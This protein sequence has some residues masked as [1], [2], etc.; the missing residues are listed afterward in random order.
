[1]LQP[2]VD[3]TSKGPPFG[4]T[5]MV[6]PY[7]SPREIKSSG[8]FSVPAS[9]CLPV[10]KF[11]KASGPFSA[12]HVFSP[13]GGPHSGRSLANRAQPL[14]QRNSSTY[15]VRPGTSQARDSHRSMT[16]PETALGRR[17]AI[18]IYGGGSPPSAGGPGE[19]KRSYG[20]DAS[21]RCWVGECLSPHLRAIG[22]APSQPAAPT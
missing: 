4:A 14:N 16:Y 9:G 6:P 19:F 5:R 21:D 1:M 3:N 22:A 13:H 15:L 8:I 18:P 20:W 10:Q 2:N 11:A 7:G 17:A 12:P